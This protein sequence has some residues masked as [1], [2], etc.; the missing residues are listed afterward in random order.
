MRNSVGGFGFQH[1]GKPATLRDIDDL[2]LRHSAHGAE[3]VLGRGK[4]HHRI[5]GLAEH[6]PVRTD[7]RKLMHRKTRRTL[8]DP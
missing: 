7:D 5:E 2:L 6:A 3:A 8:H 4:S 1:R